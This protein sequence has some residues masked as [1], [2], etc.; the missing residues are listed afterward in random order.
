MCLFV[1]VKQLHIWNPNPNFL[2][3]YITFMEL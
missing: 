1:G 2:I 3:H